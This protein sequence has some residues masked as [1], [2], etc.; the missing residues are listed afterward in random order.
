MSDAGGMETFGFQ[1]D[2]NT[3]QYDA[4]DDDM[5]LSMPPKNEL[6]DMFADLL[7]SMGSLEPTARAEMEGLSDE[8][9]WRLIMNDRQRRMRLPADYFATQL[10]RH[11]DPAMKS[12][13]VTK[14]QLVGLD[15]SISMLERLEFALRTATASFME[16]FTDHP[17]NGHTLIHEF[18]LDLP[19]AALRKG[20]NPVLLRQPGEHHLCI[21]CLKAIMENDY[22]FRKILNEDE[23]LNTIAACIRNETRKTQL[24]ALQTVALAAKDPHD[25]GI[26]VMDAIHHLGTIADEP[27]RFHTIGERLADP[28]CAKEFKHAAL[29]LFVDVMNNSPDL[30]MLVYWQMDLERA[31]MNE[32]VH[33]MDTDAEDPAV[34]ALASQYLSKLVN[35]DQIA[36]MRVESN[37]INEES[38]VEIESLKSTAAA[39]TKDRDAFKKQAQ[40]AQIKAG[41]L[42]TMIDSYR[43]EVERLNGKLD[44]AANIMMEQNEMMTE[45]RSQLEQLEQEHTQLRQQTAAMQAAGGTA[46]VPLPPV[47]QAAAITKAKS[48]GPE[49]ELDVVAKVKPAVVPAPPPM[50]PPLPP[51]M[52]GLSG[53]IPAAPPPMG[54]GI[55]GA[56]AMM[57][58]PGVPPMMGMA[59][60][61]RVTPN[62]PLP[63]VNWV[64]L[65]KITGTIFETL[66]DEQV[67]LE[68]DFSDFEKK[69]KVKETKDFV[70]QVKK[71]DDL[72][73][74]VESNRARNL[75]ITTRRIGM[76]Y[77]F[78][79][80]TILSTDLTEL[81]PEHAELLLNYVATD[82]EQTALEKHS[83]HKSKLDEAE[84]FMLEMTTVDRYESRLRVMA[85]IGYFDEILLHSKPQ[86]DALY[87]AS[88]QLANSAS[89]NKLLEIILAFGNYMN[90]AKRGSAYGFKLETFGR[91][92][93]TKSSDRTST[94]LHFIVETVT[95]NYPNVENFMETLTTIEEASKISL[96]TLQTDVSGL[97]KG[98]DLILYEREKQQNNFVIYSFYINAVHK[99]AH[100]AEKFRET[101]EAYQAVC[102][103]FNENPHQMEPFE[104]FSVFRK[105]MENWKKCLKDNE[106]RRK[107]A[108]QPK[109]KGFKV[110]TKDEFNTKFSSVSTE[111]APHPI[112]GTTSKS[113]GG[114]R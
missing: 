83:Q 30:N 101:T 7:G 51:P 59:I 27:F 89:F 90:S 48:T 21:M 113:I 40:E 98:I 107:S 111:V 52:P 39:L 45:H 84:R 62:V 65:R 43:K 20:T 85:Y 4:A 100:L 33:H 41:D 66:T 106:R 8:R 36:E 102:H 109:P 71:K 34:R 81:L 10:Q 58:A 44:E 72:I 60:K 28:G 47:Q 63:M 78:L 86:V 23:V 24:A 1:N 91:L 11:T 108:T 64:P 55:P 56:P 97:R 114:S 104:F 69:F 68:M 31:G 15:T 26:A 93:D 87:R 2:A 103:L 6:D 74:V 75:V 9:K 53:G 80:Q 42:V 70:P 35:V 25:G 82:E 73:T 16:E 110:L 19:E 61:P 17:N 99:V 46:A 76:E 79:K 29:T 94:L 22:G 14:K 49:S 112:L 13:K 96:V 37:R 67:L 5:A 57:G 3:Q 88:N 54:G 95:E 38:K 32:I 12:K 105:F 50:A 77:D 18:M 92:M